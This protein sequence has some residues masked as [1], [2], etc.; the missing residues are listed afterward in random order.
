[1]LLDEVVADVSSQLDAQ[2]KL[3]VQIRR[4]DDVPEVGPT[5]GGVWYQVPGVTAVFADLKGSTD[6]NA[7]DGPKV[8]AYAYTYFIRAMAVIMDRFSA[9]YVDI[10]GDGVFGLFSGP[11][12]QFQAVACA[13]TMR[14]QM[15]RDIAGRFQKS[16]GSDWVLSAGVGIDHGTLLV[17]RLGLRGTK[18][19]EVWAGNP[20]NMASKLSSLAD[21]N[22][23]VVS[24]RVFSLYENASRLR[25]RALLWSCGCASGV[26]GPGLDAP[27]GCTTLLW[28]QEPTPSGLGFDFSRIHRL[29]PLWCRSHGPEFCE[30]IVTGRRPG[31]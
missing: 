8:A 1:M 25:R 3:G 12:S 6:L 14:T 21:P 19:N 28:E 9:G 11:S 15:Q 23:L 17:R 7:N 27:A 31:K 24:D 20:V 26:I 13:I 5:N 10:Q 29:S 16:A 18:M 2:A 30:A 4:E 22:Q